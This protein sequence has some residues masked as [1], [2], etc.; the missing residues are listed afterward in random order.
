[1]SGRHSTGSRGSG[2]I[3]H[4]TPERGEGERELSFASKDPSV[5]SLFDNDMGR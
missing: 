3:E 5:N 4:S 2:S 1:M